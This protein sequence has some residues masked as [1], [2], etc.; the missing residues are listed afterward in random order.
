MASNDTKDD[1]LIRTIKARLRKAG[2]DYDLISERQKQYLIAIE[3]SVN[4]VFEKEQKAKDLIKGNNININR[5][6]KDI[7]VT[8]A[9][10][11]NNKMLMDYI[12]YCN[13]EFEKIDISA[14]NSKLKAENKKLRAEIEGLHSRDVDYEETKIQLKEAMDEIER[15]KTQIQMVHQGITYGVTAY[16]KKSQKVIPIR[17]MRG[18][19]EVVTW[20]VNGMRSC[21]DKGFFKF[22]TSA[23]ADVYCLQETRIYPKAAKSIHIQ[24]YNIYWNHAERKGYSG[25]AI[26]TRKK[27]IRVMRGIGVEQFDREGRV[28][29]AEYDHFFIVNCYAPASNEENSRLTYRLQF[30]DALRDYLRILD[31]LKPVLLCGDMNVILSELDIESPITTNII[32]ILPDERE[33]MK[34][35]L[36]S[37]Y[38]DAFRTLYPYKGHIYSW[39]PYAVGREKNMGLRLDYFLPSER[40]MNRVVDVQYNTNVSGSDHCP[41]TLSMKASL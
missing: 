15:L 25:T 31:S 33:K 18:L 38:V 4:I 32:S 23:N 35:L 13:K 28:L 20:N 24:G 30:D 12:N 1:A 5:I 17:Q 2:Y 10:L 19:I 14:G 29:I 6:A 8:R 22:F 39:W 41:V 36:E 27:P 9:T 34:E 16:K 26:I 37:G 7:G 40:L 11:Y 21:I 3:G